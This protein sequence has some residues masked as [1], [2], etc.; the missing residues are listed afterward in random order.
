[1][2]TGSVGEDDDEFVTPVPYVSL[3]HVLDDT[4]PA[5]RYMRTRL[6]T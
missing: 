2:P 1:M 6:R 5:T 3:Q 4:E